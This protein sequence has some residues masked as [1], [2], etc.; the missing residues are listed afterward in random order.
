MKA[1]SW[2]EGRHVHNK[3]DHSHII[4]DAC[5]ALIKFMQGYGWIGLRGGRD[6][7]HAGPQYLRLVDVASSRTI[8]VS[9]GSVYSGWNRVEALTIGAV[10]GMD[11][12]KCVVKAE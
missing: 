11:L 6:G 10:V 9:L 2:R 4:M 8:S 1:C 12:V 3:Q 7:V 5:S